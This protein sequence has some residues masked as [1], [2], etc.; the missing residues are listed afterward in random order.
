MMKDLGSVVNLEKANR[1]GAKAQR[2]R[3]GRQGKYK[4]LALPSRF[5]GY[6]FSRY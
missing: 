1:K 5:R 2:D 4:V 6:R 3:K